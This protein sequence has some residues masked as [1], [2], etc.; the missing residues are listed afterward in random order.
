MDKVVDNLAKGAFADLYSDYIQYLKL[1]RQGLRKQSLAFAEKF[2][3]SYEDDPFE[4]RQ[5][6]CWEL[7]ECTEPYWDSWPG[8][9]GWLFPGNIERKL[10][11][12][13]FEEWR[14]REP[15]NANVWL[16]PLGGYLEWRTDV[17][18]ML[19]PH[20]PRCQFA[21]LTRVGAAIGFAVHELDHLGYIL[22][23][24]TEFS[25]LI[26]ALT[27]VTE[28]IGVDLS[29]AAHETLVWLRALREVQAEVDDDLRPAMRSRGIIRP[30]STSFY[31]PLRWY[32]DA[33]RLWSR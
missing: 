11:S 30:E 4:I 10:I 8:G 22:A 20:N 28:A 26:A 14:Q 9:R 15:K 6:V 29:V 24:T 23:S 1:R 17:A 31:A 21:E 32:R 33:P 12:P 16:Y 19:E 5:K 3:S 18:F 2:I 13:M 27:A 25:E 7:F